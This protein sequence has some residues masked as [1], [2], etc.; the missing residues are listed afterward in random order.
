MLDIAAMNV[1]VGCE[2]FESLGFWEWSRNSETLKLFLSCI[3]VVT[4]LIIVDLLIE[5]EVNSLVAWDTWSTLFTIHL[6]CCVAPLFY[7]GF[8]NGIY[9]VSTALICFAFGA[10]FANRKN[11]I[12]DD[13]PAHALWHFFAASGMLFAMLWKDETIIFM[14][15]HP[16][17]SHLVSNMNIV[18]IKQA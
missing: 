10:F 2:L 17:W 7:Y 4:P 16:K 1:A 12:C 6:L 18:S 14:S 11:Y 5:T 9:L 15:T 3:F 8:K 13:L